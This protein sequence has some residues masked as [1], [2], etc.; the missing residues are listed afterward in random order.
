MNNSLF[1]INVLVTQWVLVQG[2]K[3]M[4]KD[5]SL[6]SYII[7]THPPLLNSNLLPSPWL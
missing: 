6:K 3:N 5:F 4:E 1:E 7:K 2:N